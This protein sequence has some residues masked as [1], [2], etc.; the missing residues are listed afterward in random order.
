MWASQ[1]IKGVNPGMWASQDPENSS[2]RYEAHTLGYTRVVRE[3]RVNV[4]NLLPFVGAQ[5]LTFMQGVT[6]GS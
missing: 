2:E 3:V 1:D 4:V 5:F 6:L